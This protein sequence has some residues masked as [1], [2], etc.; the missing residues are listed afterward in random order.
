MFRLI[1]AAALTGF[2][3]PALAA[4]APDKSQYHLFNPTPRESMREMSTDRPDKTES[5]YTLDAGHFQIESD[6][7]AYAYDHDSSNGAN[8]R[9]DSWS[10][11]TLNLKAGLCNFADFQVVFFPYNRVRT[12]DRIAG[13][14][15]RQ[16]GF[17][18]V[19]TRLKVNLW[20]NDGGACAGGIMP[21]VKW[22]TSQDNL[23]NRAI[24]G[25]VIL[26]VTFDLPAGFS[27]A[28]M[29][30]FDWLQNADSRDYHPEFVNSISF[31]HPIV[32]KLEAFLEFYSLV[33]A[34]N[35]AP[36]VGTVDFG[37]TYG[38]TENM[39]VDAGAYLGVTKSAADIA[40]FVGFSVRF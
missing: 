12:D 5:P 35:D 34:E 4:D 11:A 31:S 2:I 40:P 20:G 15:G 16:S 37:F 29:T 7:F 1:V 8:L 25:G 23:G 3:A 24:E 30:E 6:L 22:P 26:P 39:Q 14:I 19:L 21:F 18:D 36:W 27:A 33:S 17:G 38:I 13:T 28:M 32:G 9:G 10:F